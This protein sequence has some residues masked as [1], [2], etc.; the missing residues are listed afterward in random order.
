M[1]LISFLIFNK[2]KFV[3]KNSKDMAL[4]KLVEFIGRSKSFEECAL[5]IRYAKNKYES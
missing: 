2:E 5:F 3:E 4:I 1:K